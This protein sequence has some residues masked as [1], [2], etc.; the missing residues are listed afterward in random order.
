VRLI[1]FDVFTGGVPYIQQGYNFQQ[2]AQPMVVQTTFPP[3][4]AHTAPTVLQPALP[5]GA[6]F[7]AAESTANQAPDSKGRNFPPSYDMTTSPQ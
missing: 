2:G 4:S 3:G 5:M 7:P 1:H 6:T